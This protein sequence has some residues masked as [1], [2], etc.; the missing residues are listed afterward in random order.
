M[1]VTILMMMMMTV[2]IMVIMIIVMPTIIITIRK[3]IN[4]FKMRVVIMAKYIYILYDR[5]KCNSK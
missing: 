4:T 5:D 3:V 2:L 1:V